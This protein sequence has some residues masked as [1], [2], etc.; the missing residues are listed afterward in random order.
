MSVPRYTV[1]GS[2]VLSLLKFGEAHGAN[3]RPLEQQLRLSRET[4]AAPDTRVS[5]KVSHQV[6]EGLAQLLQAEH[7][8]LDLAEHLDLDGLDVLGHLAVN[9]VN[10]RELLDRV[11]RY[12]RIL[13]DAGRVEYEVHGQMLLVYPGCR[14]LLHAVPRHVAEYSAAL[15]LGIARLATRSPIRIDSVAFRHARPASTRRLKKVFGVEP[16]FDAVETV[17]TLEAKVLELPI[18]ANQAGV[19]TY[20]DRYAQQLLESLPREEN[21]VA[22][23]RRL[24][25]VGLEKGAPTAAFVAAQLALH[26]R[27]L[28]RRLAAEGAS[29]T[30]LLDEARRI[31]AERLLSENRLAIGEVAFLLGYAETS[32]FHRAFKRWTGRTPTQQRSR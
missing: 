26:P 3:L 2:V 24:L 10:L 30:E 28:Q 20:L 12:N 5:T 23:V 25:M 4:L 1:A 22:D 18:A 17:V 7:I 16:T 32:A 9:S 11:V 19:V 8:G 15:V 21:L 6:W 13:H 14:G 27:T 31:L 29:L